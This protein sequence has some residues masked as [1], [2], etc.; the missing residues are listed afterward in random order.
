MSLVFV[1]QFQF[2]APEQYTL[3]QPSLVDPLGQVA[4]LTARIE[5]LSEHLRENKKDHHSRR[6][7]LTMVGKRKRLL[8]YLEKT[9][10]EGYKALIQSL[11]LRR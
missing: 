4:L 5:Y 9:D 10:Y 6:G 11:G 8:T 3:S 1:D 2:V 7:L